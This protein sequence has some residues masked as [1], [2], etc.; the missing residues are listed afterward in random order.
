MNGGRWEKNWNPSQFETPP[1]VFSYRHFP[2]PHAVW[3]KRIQGLRLDYDEYQD[4]GVGEPEKVLVY[5]AEI[6]DE[7]VKYLGV[8][9]LPRNRNLPKG[10][11]WFEIDVGECIHT[12]PPPRDEC[13][14]LFVSTEGDLDKKNI[15]VMKPARDGKSW[16]VEVEVPRDGMEVKMGWIT[17]WGEN[18]TAVGMTEE[19][20]RRG[21]TGSWGA[22]W[23][24]AWNKE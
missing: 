19:D 1:D 11:H 14:L 18:K 7:R 9:V 5:T 3:E 17:E 16:G 20:W 21:P 23:L 15:F 8:N 24:A 10:R 12:P 13:V 6:R 2:H 22:N 4:R